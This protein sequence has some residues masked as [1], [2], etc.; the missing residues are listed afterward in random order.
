MY[1]RIL[2][3]GSGQIG[4]AILKKLNQLLPEAIMIHN[5]TF[6]ENQELQSN[7]K[8]E[9]SIEVSY[10]YGNIFMPYH[11][12]DLLNNDLMSKKEDIINYFYQEIDECSLKQSTL[13]TIVSR[14]NP[15]II[16][17][18]INTAT[19]LGRNYNPLQTKNEFIN[20]AQLCCEQILVNDFTGKI[21]AFVSAL[22]YV[23]ESCGVKKYIKVSTTGLG[24]MGFNIPYTH[25]DNPSYN[26]SNALM[27]KISASGVLHQLLW[28]LEHTKGLNIS[29]IIPATF[30][31][32][33][34]VKNDDVETDIGYVKKRMGIQPYFIKEG[35]YLRYNDCQFGKPLNFCVVRA[36]ENHVY[37]INEV[38]AL[39]AIGQ[40]ESITKEEVAEAVIKDFYGDTSF[41]ILATMDKTMLGPTYLGQHMIHKIYDENIEGALGVATGNLG[42]TASKHLYE[43]YFIKKIVPTM[44]QIEKL[45]DNDYERITIDINKRLLLETNIIEEAISLGIPI[46]TNNGYL[47]I[48]DYS[49]TPNK[50][51][52][53]ILTY[54]NI[55]KWARVGWIDLRK[56]NISSI[57]DEIKMVAIK[58]KMSLCDQDSQ[59]IDNNLNDIKDDYNIGELLAAIYNLNNKGRKK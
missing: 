25:G 43:L 24:G 3:I 37:S 47:Y 51:Q 16:I 6:G 58:R 28:N 44:Q 9:E 21:I 23:M 17:D 52:R 12:K 34:S 15:D 1:K 35:K 42:V 14:F 48:G 11:L 56:K 41:N 46:I 19:V 2:L 59:I 38:H 22:K 36:G 7:F 50:M 45:S 57:L 32:I 5:L 20:D 55:N 27:G 31:G 26:L 33:D 13:Y 29:L 30:V 40:M 39:A 49:L 10:S 8:F 4:K 18:A 53:N 54:E